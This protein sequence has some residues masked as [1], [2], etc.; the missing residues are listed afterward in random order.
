MNAFDA[1]GGRRVEAGRPGAAL[2][3][4]RG[5]GPVNEA[6]ARRQ[7]ARASTLYAEL[8]YVTAAMHDLVHEGWS[9]GSQR[10][11]L[12]AVEHARRVLREQHAAEV[13]PGDMASDSVT[14]IAARPVF[15]N[16][17]GGPATATPRGVR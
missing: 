3:V 4:L 17:V 10:R 6:Q 11:A 7:A 16:A 8:E 15:T 5:G 9:Y 12:T 1:V 13:A 2:Q 14:R